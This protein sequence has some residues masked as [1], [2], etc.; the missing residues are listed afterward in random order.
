MQSFKCLAI[1]ICTYLAACSGS[2]QSTPNPVKKDSTASLS[3]GQTAVNE[4]PKKTII[5]FLHWYKNNMTRLD[6]FS[7]VNTAFGGDTT[8]FYS[9]N[10]EAT[11]AYL[12]EFKKSGFVSD[13]Y[14]QV[15]RGYFKKCDDYLKKHPEN[16]GP[17]DGFEFDLVMWSQ[18]YD[19]DL[20]NIDKSKVIDQTIADNKATVKLGFPT[21]GHLLYKLSKQ[22]DK[23]LIDR[24]ENN[25]TNKDFSLPE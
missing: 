2:D 7:L 25:W 4:H 17:P 15:M 12:A 9:V 6:S 14:V 18:E 5:D 13:K 21:G 19:E 22:G 1:G 8:K 16:D 20:A 24:I 11:E 3:P 10:F 23:W